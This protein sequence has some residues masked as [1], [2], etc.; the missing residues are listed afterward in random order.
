MNNTDN[1]NNDSD[2]V[3]RIDSP[4]N[5]CLLVQEKVEFKGWFSADEK[6]YR[7]I[8]KGSAK[9]EVL[10]EEDNDKDQG[11]YSRL[12]FVGE[13]LSPDKNQKNKVL[14]ENF[15]IVKNSHVR[16]KNPLAFSYAIS[17]TLNFANILSETEEKKF[18]LTIAYSY[19]NQITL[20]NYVQI[21]VAP[22]NS[23]ENIEGGFINLD[24]YLLCKKNILLEGWVLKK[25]EKL[26]KVE[27]FINKQFFALAETNL[28]FP[29]QKFYYPGHQNAKNSRFA[30]LFSK[31]EL[32]R[33]I[34][35]IDLEK[36]FSIDAKCHFENDLFEITGP[37]VLWPDIKKSKLWGRI[38]KV[39]LQENGLI[40]IAGWLVNTSFFPVRLLL[41]GRNRRVEL[42]TGKFLEWNNRS[43]ITNRFS[44]I[45]TEENLGFSIKVPPEILGKIPGEIKLVAE[46]IEKRLEIGSRFWG[47]ISDLFRKTIRYKNKF[48]EFAAD[49]SQVLCRLGLRKNFNQTKPYFK[50]R[51]KSPPQKI[52]IAT[53]NLSAV[54]GAPKILYQ[55]VKKMTET[56]IKGENLLVISPY[57]G[58][59]ALQYQKLGAK[60]VIENS[61]D[62]NLQNWSKYLSSQKKLSKIIQSFSP[63]L[64]LCGTINSFWAA[65]YALKERIPYYWCI[66]ES[67]PPYQAF[68]HLNFNLREIYHNALS[69]CEKAFFAT[70]KTAELYKNFIPERAIKI[71]PNGVDI[72]QIEKEITLL[73]KENARKN[74]GL[75][76]EIVIS[77]IGTTAGRKGQDIF[78][79]EMALL[80]NTLKKKD[81]K[82]FIVGAREGQFVYDLFSL[83][84][85]LKLN[86]HITIVPETSAVAPYYLASDIMVICSKEESAP[87]VSLEAFAYGRP[88]VSTTAFGLADQIEDGKN[89]LSYRSE[90]QGELATKIASLIN[91]SDL[92]QK[93]ISAAKKTVEEKY[94]LKQSLTKYLEAILPK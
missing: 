29:E 37:F 66:Q 63:D 56:K 11:Y 88:L 7:E 13:K 28:P 73:S 53:H 25:S 40:E 69:H 50:N 19:K 5:G 22:K 51:I 46:T 91:S 61:L 64:F 83:V 54:E 94:S 31:K 93:L 55:I 9:L 10:L 8:E 78:I 47:I 24:R 52:I 75:K 90:N 14:L 27:I 59:L 82:F 76:N 49:I 33:K 60:V 67:I 62:C 79:K 77:I 87:L 89:A 71:I 74:L 4:G 32:L 41:E 15:T 92:Q 2:L 17:G 58:E 3:V 26:K 81:F 23:W 16:L 42:E 43:D 85:E 45:S 35:N 6:Q 57:D 48:E 30:L 65:D 36:E 84:E 70:D 21:R 34:I 44:L 20:A 39:A 68:S 72:E 12:N 18:I 80:K 86:K 38:E 1:N